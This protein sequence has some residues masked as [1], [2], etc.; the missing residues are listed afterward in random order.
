MG[1]RQQARGRLDHCPGHACFRA[2]TNLRRSCKRASSER[3]YAE[4]VVQK[5]RADA[6]T[7]TPDPFI[8]SMAWDLRRLAFGHGYPRKSAAFSYRRSRSFSAGCGCC[9]A[10]ALPPRIDAPRA[11]A[12]PN[13]RS[14]DGRR[15][16]APSRPIR[17]CWRVRI[18]RLHRGDCTRAAPESR[19]VLRTPP[20]SPTR[21]SAAWR[22]GGT[23][24]IGHQ[25]A[26]SV[27]RSDRGSKL[28]S[29]AAPPFGVLAGWSG[30]GSDSRIAVHG[31]LTAAPRPYRR[32]RKARLARL[33]SGCSRP[34]GCDEHIGASTAAIARG[35]GG[36]PRLGV[37]PACAN[38]GR[39]H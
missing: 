19:S 2:V 5:P 38:C 4:D 18:R 20:S 29:L 27:R 7:R 28:S 24:A 37:V 26:L 11:S 3:P 15:C 31:L 16:A 17:A 35:L 8:T 21:S 25:V 30:S 13:L 1:G 10:T 32:S 12:R 36:R 9:V 34:R 23:N 14:T 22:R 6:G 33:A 39:R